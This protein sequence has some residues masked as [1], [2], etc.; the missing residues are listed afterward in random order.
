MS[1]EEKVVSS[2]DLQAGKIEEWVRAHK[3]PYV[4]LTKAQ[5]IEAAKRKG[6]EFN[7]LADLRD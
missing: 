1:D 5:R 3:K 7:K 4:P 6:R 2:V